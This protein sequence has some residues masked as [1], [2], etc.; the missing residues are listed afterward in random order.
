MAKHSFVGGIHPYDGKDI[1][2]KRSIKD[3]F[4]T[5]DMVYPL[6]QHIG[7]PAVPV[8]EKGD[9]VKRGQ[10]IAVAGG[11]V[12][13]NIY[14]SVSGTVKSIEPRRV[15]TGDMVNSIIIT[16]D[17]KYDEVDYEAVEDLDTLSK[18]DII[19]RIQKAGIVG[20]GGAG[21]PTHVKL[22]VKD[23]DKIDYC[24]ANCAECEPYLTS[25]YRRMVEE[26]EK[27]VEGLRIILRLFDNAKGILAVEDN[28]SDCI[29]NLKKLVK[30]D[31]RI[32]VKTLKTKYP[33]GSERHLIFATTKRAIN[34]DMLPA[35]AGCVVN[36]VDTIVAVYNA[37]KNGIP[38][39][40]R[41]VTV[42]GDCVKKP[43]NFRVHIGM[44]YEQ[45]LEEAGGLK[46]KPEKIVSGGPMMGFALPDLDVPTT[47]TASALLTISRDEVS[48]VEP[49]PC[50]NC[51]LCVEVCPGRIVPTLLAD[52]ADRKDEEEFTEKGGMECCECGCCSYI[53][54]AKRNLTQSI[55]T[56]RKTV[57]AN[58][59][60]K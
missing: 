12:S 21:F 55:K 25:D 53:C 24:I 48:R 27:L 38:L 40:E 60:K 51:G 6:V 22:S 39:M 50:I 33:Q 3:V 26:P 29:E 4:P 58:R 15:V 37:V 35:D 16:N 44:S 49:G 13:S 42:T 7:A 10:I 1:S 19:E 54:P 9:S 18:G 28:K 52:L 46:K 31:P 17:E 2:K 8:V 47:K 23:P 34:C 41:I 32:M 20:M 30:D 45:L 5:G 43:Q 11:F 36:N 56:M 14:S 57:L 59:K